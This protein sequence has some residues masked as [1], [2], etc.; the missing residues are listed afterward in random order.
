M[1]NIADE[2]SLSNDGGVE[3]TVASSRSDL[4]SGTCS[5]QSVTGCED[6][7]VG[8]TKVPRLRF[9]QTIKIGTWNCGG[10]T[11]TTQELCRDLGYDVLVLT[12]T[13]D[14]GSLKP[15]SKFITAEPAPE[16]DSFSG[17]AIMLSDRVAK[18]V[19][20]S[21]RFGSR[22][23]FVEIK[24]DP[25]NL[26]VIGVYSP[27]SNRKQSPF[28]AD[29]LE[30]LEQL[31]TKINSSICTIVLGDLNCK[32]GR[33]IEHLTG[34]WCIHD[35]PNAGGK[36][37]IDLLRKFN[38]SAVSTFFQP[39]KRKNSPSRSNATYLSK[40]PRYKPSQID[41]AIVS[42]RWATS[43]KNCKVKWGIACQRWGRHYDHGLIECILK[44]R[45]CRIKR[46]P[47][48]DYSVLSSDPGVKASFDQM[49]NENL[50]RQ[51]INQFDPAAAYANL[52]R[53]INEAAESSLP[54]KRAR[55][56]RK[57]KVSSR[58]KELYDTRR[59]NYEKMTKEEQNAARR[60]ISKSTR[61]DY[62]AYID[63]I[64]T[65]ME[66]AERSGNSREVTKLRKLLSSNN[67][68]SQ[69]MPSKD[70]K[71]DP[72]LSEKQLLDS[73]NEFLTEKF[74][75]PS[76]DIGRE[77]EATVPPND[78]LLKDELE[79]AFKSLKTGKA[80]GWDKIPIEAFKYST[81][82]K[83]ELFRITHLIWDTEIVPADMLI[84]IFIM[85][86]K[87]NNRND[88]G[89]YRAICLLC[90]AY[91]LLSALIARRLHVE[92]APIFPDSQAGFRP[93]RG[94][95]DNVCILKWTINMIIRENREAIVTFI[96]YKAAFDTESQLFLDEALSSAGVSTKVR[97]V[98][99]SIFNV[100][101]GCVRIGNSTSD[102]FDI[103]RGVLQGD[104]FSPVAFIAGLWRIFS[105]YDKPNA[106]IIVGTAPYEVEIKA[107]EYADDAG[108]IDDKAAETTDRL[109]SISR[110][111]R[112]EA[113]MIIS[114]PKTKGMHIHKSDKV[115]KTTEEEVTA[116]G[117]KH[118]CPNC[119]R[120][121]P[122]M[123]GMK[124]HLAR[125]C[126][127]GQTVRS[128]KGSL[129]DKAVKLTKQ[130]AIEN[131]RPHVYM[132]E[133][134]IDNVHS[135]VYLGSKTQCDGDSRAD[136][137]HRMDIAQVAFSSLFNLWRDHRIPL[138]MKIRLYRA[139]VCSTF[140]HA[141]EAWDLTEEIHKSVNG[142]N[143]RCL[144]IITQKCH[145]ETAS[146]PV[147]N[148]TLAIRKRRL[149]YLG[150]IL[151]LADDRLLKRTLR[152][153]V[154]T[155]AG[156]PQGSLLQDCGHS[157]FGDLELMARDRKRWNKFVNN[158]R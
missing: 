2:T 115:S 65:D 23:A 75:P 116:L 67:S 113:A 129:A 152:A 79:T 155:N 44:S 69:T 41:Y 46:E 118:T 9:A 34:K 61:D 123:R 60:A 24:A 156:P 47:A 114:V 31:L 153:Y 14:K 20:H 49:V 32:L 39:A 143:S 112:E 122:T 40:D 84:G 86:Y 141:C 64:I 92:L 134:Q 144:H 104:I 29:T 147:F 142:F 99:Q 137:K 133:E 62:L 22:I 59:A 127:E 54:V 53:S 94:T 45:I 74:A 55:P 15:N 77:R 149:R 6:T 158:L 111:S 42:K 138:S 58:T 48:K 140:T 103:S 3:S 66:A 21:G 154:C 102:P 89:N 13:H 96:D 157:T 33:N 25:C 117:L 70:M 51:E 101:S 146:N 52:C 95:R 150:H 110:R 97:R 83:Q 82:A 71:G 57:R 131:E 1:I 107:L 139:A 78:P 100:A 151:R 10:L 8:R 4:A 88:F 119:E 28:M 85:L 30:Q 126:D 12:E 90:H 87:K 17:V 63:S 73:W 37:M 27:H 11:F 5:P 18:C 130:K 76:V 128:R 98:I 106:G 43:I 50:T 105:S 16:N 124:I 93:A 56:M 132:E 68:S 7:T 26:F 35:K 148:L 125:W 121:F 108:L 135:F 109:S 80:P 36:K 38:L 72:I 81:A 91:K 145:R 19:V 136:M 120:P